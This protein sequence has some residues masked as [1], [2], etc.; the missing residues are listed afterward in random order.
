MSSGD[1]EPADRRSASERASSTESG[2]RRESSS[3]RDGGEHS[4]IPP[5]ADLAAYGD[6]D[7]KLPERLISMAE[8]CA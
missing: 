2:S 5:A 1:I 8:R 6:I 4:L 3:R 7:A